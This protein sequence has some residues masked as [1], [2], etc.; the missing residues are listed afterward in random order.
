MMDKGISVLAASGSGPA[1]ALY[2]ARSRRNQMIFF[3]LVAGTCGVSFVFDLLL[4]GKFGLVTIALVSLTIWQG[5]RT[6]VMRTVFSAD[7]IEHRT[8]LGVSQEAEYSKIKFMEGEDESIT[9]AGEDLLGK[10]LEF[11]LRKR[12]GNLEEVAAFL[13]RRIDR[14]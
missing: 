7:R 1:G 12:D 6:Y 11:T 13:R 9:I 14:D 8:A 3:L 2:V 5:L 4:S 10:W